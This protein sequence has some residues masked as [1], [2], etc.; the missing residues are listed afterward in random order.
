MKT[1]L[2]KHWA[3]NGAMEELKDGYISENGKLVV[4]FLQA[5]HV[6]ERRQADLDAHVSNE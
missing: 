1:N 5:I 2:L 4:H 6:L 3:L